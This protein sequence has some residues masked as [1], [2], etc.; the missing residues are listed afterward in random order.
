MPRR[1]VLGLLAL[2]LLAAPATAHAMQF[3]ISVG[4]RAGTLG[5]GADVAVPLGRQVA[6]RGGAGLLGFDVDMTGRFGLADHRTAEL[7]LPKALYTIGA[8]VSFLGLR[9]GA[10]ILIKSGDPTY[11]IDLDQGASIDI[12]DNTYTEPAVGTLTTTY[13]WSSGAPYL[14]VGLG[15]LTGAGFGFLIDV[16]AVLLEDSS[17]SMSATGDGTLIAS[18]QFLDDLRTEERAVRDDAGGWADF[19]PIVSIGFRLGLP[20]GV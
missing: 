5:I 9:A 3:G 2:S 18:S 12:G 19:W 14:T 20:G 13:G 1:P 10:G 7:S 6:I 17:F 11:R 15:S 8:E 4:A 16:G